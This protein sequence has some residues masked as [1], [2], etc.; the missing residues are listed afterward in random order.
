MKY[1]KE[2]VSGRYVNLI[3]YNLGLINQLSV[4]ELMNPSDIAKSTYGLELLELEEREKIVKSI[5]KLELIDFIKP[6]WMCLNL[7]NQDEVN[8]NRIHFTCYLMLNNN[9]NKLID[10]LITSLYILY[11]TVDINV[12]D[13]DGIKL[14]IKKDGKA[15]AFIDDSNFIDLCECMMELCCFDR[16]KGEEKINGNAELVEIVRRA[17]RK[18]QEKQREKNELSFEEKVREVIHMKNCFYDDLKNITIW[19]LNDFYKTSLYI[20]SYDKNYQ[21]ASSGNLKIKEIKD[22]KE[23]TKIMREERK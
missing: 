4:D 22:W 12:L 14:I 3:K 1:G 7:D 21:L 19:Q 5:G 13:A 8:K 11:K 16:P 15:I 9:E 20:D 10:D 6:F 17:E 18:H 23:Q 2:C